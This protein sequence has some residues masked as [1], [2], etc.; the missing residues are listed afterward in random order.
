MNQFLLKRQ[1]KYLLLVFMIFLMA[2]IQPIF[3][4]TNGKQNKKEL[5]NKKKKLNEEIN[6]INSL[7][8][9]TKANKKSSINQLVALNKKISIREEL[10]NTINAEIN[11]LNREIKQNQKETDK[12]KQNLEKLK[13]DYARMIYFAQRNRDSYSRLVFIFASGDFNQAYM[14]LKYFQ[15][16]SQFRKKQAEEI[17]NAQTQILAKLNELKEKRHE[18][19]LLLGNEEVEKTSLSKEKEDQ[20]VVLTE[21]QKKEKELKGE[22][23]KKRRETENL[24]LAIKKLIEAEIKR[25]LEEAA[26]ADAVTIAAKKAKTEKNLKN[27]KVKE[28]VEPKK[29]AVIPEL[30]DEAVELSHDFS[31]NRGKLPWPVTKGFI[32]EEYGEHEH[33]AIKGFMMVNNGVE[34]SSSQGAQVRAVFDGEV[35][36]IAESPTGGKLVIIRHGEYLSVYVNLGEVSV[37]RGDKVTVKQNIGNIKFNE[38]ENK[39]SM[40]LQIWKGQTKMD[41]ALWLSKGK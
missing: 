20:E 10:I 29:E 12:L 33:P 2:G 22:L 13:A 31:N 17:I 3:S 24:Q 4:Q 38:D 6:E 40:N 1:S 11:Q 36:S 9:E 37:K 39:S 7:L 35:T 27:I 23:E 25:K 32:S 8:D 21:L 34:I 19:N 26:K 28:S 30:S 41:P 15:Q 5:E 16:Y 14:R 18:K